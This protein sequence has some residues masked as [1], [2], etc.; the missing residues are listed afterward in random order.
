MLKHAFGVMEKLLSKHWPMIY[1]IGFTSD[2][3][4]RFWNSRYGYAQDPH[5]EW[6]LMVIV[7]AAMDSVGPA[8][9]EA[10]LIQKY[11]G[12]PGMFQKAVAVFSFFFILVDP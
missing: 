11:K 7:Y 4:L 3:H 10:A 9:V 1:K 2:P 6:E 5:H 12:C 8:F